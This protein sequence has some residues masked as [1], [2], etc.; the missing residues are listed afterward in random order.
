MSGTDF[1]EFERSGWARRSG[2]YDDGFG[3]MT[4]R[5]HERLLDA[6]GVT[7]GTRVL[8]VGCGTGRLGAAALARGAVV[9]ATDAVQ[10]MVEVAAEALPGARVLRAE[11]PGLPF[12]VGEFD[13]VVG[14][15]V[16]NHVPDPAAAVAELC[17]AVR[18]GGRVVLS[19]WDTLAGN[20][21]QGV[22][23][24]AVRAVGVT[25]PADLPGS[26]PFARY[27]APA[28][29]AALLEEAGL[30]EVQVEPV[31][32]THRVDPA[33]WWQDVL[34][35]TVLTSSL[36][37][38]QDAPTVEKIRA[39]YDDLVGT[40]RDGDEVALPVAALL[41]LGTRVVAGEDAVEHVTNQEPR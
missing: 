20:R 39:A 5:L 15:F 38:G 11:L 41:A 23:F 35:G 29:F 8:E 40:Y 2:T 21:A 36:I 27:A 1:A 37:E 24:D 7:R 33:R 31:G 32:W 19:C 14:A 28:D 25:P 26:S 12:G 4:A 10:Q 6:A 34:G 13:A 17:E 9:T 30:R 16:I 22:F 18:P 3:A